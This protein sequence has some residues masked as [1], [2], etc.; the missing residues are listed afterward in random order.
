[1]IK[2]GK[3]KHHIKTDDKR[4]L[5]DACREAASAITV[6]LSGLTLVTAKEVENLQAVQGMDIMILEGI[7]L[8]M[9]QAKR[10]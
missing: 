4:R 9:V 5:E 3:T 8:R 6:V 7:I 10:I 2:I 1:M